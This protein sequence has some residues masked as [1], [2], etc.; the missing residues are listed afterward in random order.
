MRFYALVA[1]SLIAGCQSVP[2]VQPPILLQNKPMIV[3]RHNGGVQD[4]ACPMWV[5]IDDAMKGE[6]ENGR[7]ISVDVEPGIR[8]VS[9]GRSRGGVFGAGT[10]CSG[11]LDTI[12]LVTRDVEVAG[13]PVK[14]A[15]EVQGTGKRWI[16]LVGLF[17]A[18]TPVLILD[19]E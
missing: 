15:Y 13:K 7:S 4:G 19:E 12:A 16:P 14:L 6:L 18:P 9:V 17:L 3:V 11:S 2:H 10:I 1:T 8:K 5:K